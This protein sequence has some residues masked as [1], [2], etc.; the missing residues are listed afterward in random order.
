M[1]ARLEQRLE[2]LESARRSASTLVR[3][4][5]D[6]LPAGD[7]QF[8]ESV[9]VSESRTP[10]YSALSVPDLRRLMDIAERFGRVAP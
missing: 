9:G 4:D 6:A 2:R 1:S 10:D 7:R 3:L 8:I 5:L